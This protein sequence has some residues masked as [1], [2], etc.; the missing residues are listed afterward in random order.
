M[1]TYISIL[2]GIN[3]SGHHIIKMEALRQLYTDIG[4]VNIET[5]IQSGNVVFQFKKT[6]ANLLE[7]KIKKAITNKLKFDVPILVK[8]LSE[9]KQ[10][11]ENNPFILNKAIDLAHLHITFLSAKPTQDNFAA[12]IAGNYLPD[13][14]KLI[15]KAIYLHC[16]KGYGNSKLTNSFLEKKLGVIA[17]TRNWKTANQLIH[18]AE[19]KR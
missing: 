8:E 7:S 4:F 15:E 2:R 19:A 5:Y 1:T 3:V 13:E 9:F 11:V 16:P 10:I 14:L 12:L 18:I 6:E 17:T